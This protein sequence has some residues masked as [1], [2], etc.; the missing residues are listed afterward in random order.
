M[1]R[2]RAPKTAPR[3]W[4]RYD[5]REEV[6]AITFDAN[7]AARRG[8]ARRGLDQYQ[9]NDYMALFRQVRGMV[10]AGVDT[11]SLYRSFQLMPD[12]DLAVAAYLEA[13]ASARNLGCEP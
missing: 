1:S 7:E 13:V 6:R 12:G 4:R 11:D 5:E 2:S 8:C 3:R 10:M 9:T